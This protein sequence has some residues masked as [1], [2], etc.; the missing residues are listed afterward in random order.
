MGLAH[1]QYKFWQGF[2]TEGF[3]GSY[4]ISFSVDKISIMVAIFQIIEKEELKKGYS[5]GTL[6]DNPTFKSEFDKLSKEIDIA[7]ERIHIEPLKVR[8]FL[9]S[10]GYEKCKND[11]VNYI[12]NNLGNA[13]D[14][15]KKYYKF[16]P[17]IFI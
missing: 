11:A 16:S 14:Y 4:Y 8:Y 10:N 15:M 9:D 5:K 13:I 7:S 1:F 6:R 2:I 3:A 17:N 12:N